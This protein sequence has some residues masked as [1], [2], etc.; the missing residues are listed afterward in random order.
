M[1]SHPPLP[2]LCDKEE[3]ARTVGEKIAIPSQ[4]HAG[5]KLQTCAPIYRVACVRRRRHR[6]LARDP[7]MHTSLYHSPQV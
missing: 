7:A 4:S 3:N 1:A 2:T 6:L 5:G